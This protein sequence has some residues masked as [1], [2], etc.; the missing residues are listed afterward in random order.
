GQRVLVV[1]DLLATGGT[2]GACCRLLQHND[3]EIAGCVFCI[4]LTALGGRAKLE[5]YRVVSLLSY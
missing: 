3:V 4:E 2:V 1:D 5:P